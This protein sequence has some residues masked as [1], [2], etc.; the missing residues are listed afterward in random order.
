MICF[1]QNAIQMLDPNNVL[2]RSGFTAFE[3]N[4]FYMWTILSSCINSIYFPVVLHEL[5]LS[6]LHGRD[7]FFHF[8]VDQHIM[9][10]DLKSG[11]LELKYGHHE[12]YLWTFSLL[13]LIFWISRTYCLITS[14]LLIYSIVLFL[15]WSYLGHLSVYFMWEHNEILH[16]ILWLLKRKEPTMTTEIIPIICS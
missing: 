16:R 15:C 14:C 12:K 3:W 1:L 4:Y 7:V 13:A 2:S 10:L 6:S 5:Y 8:W 11:I 9:W